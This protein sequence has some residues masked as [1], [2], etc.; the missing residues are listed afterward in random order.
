MI[1]LKTNAASFLAFKKSSKIFPALMTPKTLEIVC[2]RK[3]VFASD[4]AAGIDR[5][6]T[7]TLRAVFFV[8]QIYFGYLEARSLMIARFGIK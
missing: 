1:G 6:K 7:S 5:G 2:K 3:A 8:G 4:Y